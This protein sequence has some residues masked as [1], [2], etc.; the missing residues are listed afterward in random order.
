MLK[1]EELIMGE[2]YYAILT[3]GGRKFEHIFISS[4]TN[5]LMGNGICI[6]TK[7]L[8]TGSGT[9]RV[10]K[11]NTEFLRE[12]T[13]EEIEWLQDS[14]KADKFIEKSINQE[15]VNYEIY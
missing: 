15:S 8:T 6:T 7:G 11:D 10:V 1:I 4:G 12:A 14:E 3:N 13:T 5:G 2:Y 9:R